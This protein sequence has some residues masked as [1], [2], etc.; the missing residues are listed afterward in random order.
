MHSV[1]CLPYVSVRIVALPVLLVAARAAAGTTI[2]VPAD[3][4]TIQAAIDA[5][6]SGDTVE[7]SDGTY[8]EHIG[9]HGKAITVK[10]VNG[11][12]ATFIDGLGTPCVVSFGSGEPPDATLTGFT[13]QH[14]KSDLAYSAGGICV[15]P[16]SPTISDNVIRLNAGSDALGIGIFG[17]SPIIRGNL[18]TQNR[19]N[20]GSGGIGGGGIAVLGS[21][22]AQILNNIISDNNI[23]SSGSGGG[24]SL[25]AAGPVIIRGNLISGNT[26]DGDGGGITMVNDST[27]LIA[28]NIIVHNTAARGG[29]IAALV[30]SGSPGPRIIN[31]TIVGNTALGTGSE[32][33]FDGFVAQTQVWNNLFFGTTAQ[34]AVACNTT[35]TSTPPALHFNDAFNSAGLAYSG[36][37]ATAPGSNGNISVDPLFVNAASDYHLQAASLAIDAG[38]NAAPDLGVD[39]FASY[40]RI[41][42]G[43]GD[44]VATVDIGAYE[45]GGSLS[46]AL[47]PASLEFPGQ[48]V[49]SNRSPTQS[50]TL[51]N[52]GDGP[53]VISSVTITGDFA[54]TNS[55]GGLL[56]R[57]KTCAFDIT[58]TPTAV[59]TRTGSLSIMDDAPGSPH[60][61]VLA[62]TANDFAIVAAPGGA[63]SAAVEAGVTARY[64]LQ[65]VPVGAFGD[66]VALACEGAPGQAMC[67]LSTAAVT[68]D[69]GV[70]QFT[71]SVSTA[72]ATA[73]ASSPARMSPP[74]VI[75][76]AVFALVAMALGALIYRAAPVRRPSKRSEPFLVPAFTFVAAAYLSLSSCS[77]SSSGE[78]PKGN[79]MNGMPGST[80]ELRITGVAAGRSH[81]LPLQLTINS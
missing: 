4:T 8:K 72:A 20:S 60:S 79:G 21:S 26:T 59:G 11:A 40:V 10:S 5:A 32:V 18:I 37:C 6:A 75:P 76:I 43:N 30:P 39:D 64:E 71:V 33:Y 42:D 57:G 53:L 46:L 55:C 23:M 61:V 47:A 34:T 7:V 69:G 77:G 78:S 16:A 73:L 49:G 65:V 81:T 12:G 67:T 31:N 27:P 62:G 22:S 9:F 38:S 44:N 1:S 35:Y 68:L 51:T 2:H 54:Q 63:T 36:S 50:V 80:Y 19:R 58:F 56:D 28:D 14:G 3:Y 52:R 15:G 48:L 41:L 17:G 45:F 29:G 13:I 24:I 70:A 74:R 66:T 25:F